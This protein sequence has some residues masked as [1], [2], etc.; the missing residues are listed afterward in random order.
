MEQMTTQPTTISEVT[1]V[2]V[3]EHR[4]QGAEQAVLAIEYREWLAAGNNPL[5]APMTRFFSD[6]RLDP[7][8]VKITYRV[9]EREENREPTPFTPIDG[10]SRYA[11]TTFMHHHVG[12]WIP[13]A[14]LTRMTGGM[15]IDGQ[16][17]LGAMAVRQ[18]NE[19]GYDLEKGKVDGKVNYRLVRRAES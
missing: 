12:E 8:W 13:V 7:R 5:E 3:E 1:Q 16:G 19:A 14:T 2:I 10:T 15:R 4:R 17:V 18:L 6:P 11:V 9:W